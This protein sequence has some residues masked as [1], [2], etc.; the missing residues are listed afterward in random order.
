MTE[1]DITR[2]SA[3]SSAR[4]TVLLTGPTSGIG[5]RMLDELLR[6]PSRPNLV[7]LARDGEALHR[8][9]SKARDR[10]LGADGI[11]V[12][13]ADLADVRA[14]LNDIAALRATGALAPIDAVILNA[15]AQFMDARH[16]GAQGHELTFTVNVLAQHLLLRGLEPHLAP[17]AHVVLLGSS[18]HRGKKAS[19]HLVPDPQW[20]DPARIAE[21]KPPASGPVRA[22]QERLDGGVAYATSKLALVTLS[23][24]WADRLRASGRRLNTYDPGLVTGTG[25]VRD[26]PAYRY[27]VWKNLMPIMSILPGATTA[28]VT[29]R[30]AVGLA[31]GDAHPT[32]D[33]G[34]VE[35]GRVTSAE[36]VTFDPD[37]RR[38]LWAW[39]EGA[40]AA[41]MPE[42]VGALDEGA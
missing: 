27:W 37:R 21:A 33:D 10:G 29:A 4:P 30:H 35:I 5:A 18:T 11:Q 15:G 26:M 1:T 39:L 9:V 42:R 6:H 36:P 40:V 7:L 41:W 38:A 31:L 14:A 32:L 22:A 25:L 23:H 34:Y 8:A 24:D 17:R 20:R 12:D 28:P 2:P 13:L 19:F 3:R 16:R